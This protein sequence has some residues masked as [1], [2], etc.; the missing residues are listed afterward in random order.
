MLWVLLAVL[1]SAPV[2]D[3]VEARSTAVRWVVT[4][5]L[6][7]IWTLGAVCLLVQRDVFLTGLRVIVPAGCAT[8]LVAIVTGASVDAYSVAALA[9]AAVATAW[10]LGPWVGEAWVDGSSY[11]TEMRLPLRP[12]VL[13]SSVVVPVTWALVVASAA[14][15]PLLL[16]AQQW[17]LGGVLTVGGAGVVAVGARALHQL[18]RRWL[19]L[20]P[21]GMVLHDSLVMPE[22][23]L[24]LRHM[25]ANLGPSPAEPPAEAVDLSAGAPG[26]TLLL[27][28]SEPVEL[29]LRRRGRDTATVP[30][31]AVLF[32]PSR[33]GRVLEAASKRRIPVG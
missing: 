4:I 33:P 13:F 2:G 7:A 20:V 1:A 12:P 19:V 28:L 8:V 29:L 24:F 21:T 11:G 5:G 10:V 22:P 31:T 9:V 25:I 14:A 26:L 18:S 23:Q 17:L 16:A 32:T 3:V 6:W 30:A 15:G 27:E